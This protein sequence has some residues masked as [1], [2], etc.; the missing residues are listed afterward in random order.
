MGHSSYDPT[1]DRPAWN[2]GRKLGAKRPLKHHSILGG[3]IED[4]LAMAEAAEV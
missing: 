2:W 1:D 3:D 4:V